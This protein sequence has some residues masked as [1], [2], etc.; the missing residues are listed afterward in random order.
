MGLNENE[1]TVYIVDYGLAKSFIS[2]TTG[3]HIPFSD[4]NK[5]TGTARYASIGTHLGYEQSRRDDLESL[6]Y[7]LVY[8]LKG[9]LPWQRIQVAGKKERRKKICEKKMS[10][11]VESLCKGLPEPFADFLRLSKCL[12][13]EEKPNYQYLRKLFKNYF[14]EAKLN[15]NFVFDWKKPAQKQFKEPQRTVSF[16]SMV[17][18]AH[19]EKKEQLHILNTIQKKL[20]FNIINQKVDER[21]ISEGDKL[22]K[23]PLVETSPCLFTNDSNIAEGD[24]GMYNFDNDDIAESSISFYY[25]SGLYTV[26]KSS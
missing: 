24:S 20:S 4:D 11:T 8:M 7:T 14:L 13:F 25:C 22:L 1:D 16:D 3:K 2:K 9:I 12:S 21:K 19:L 26:R 18:M 15:T 10:T 23:V 5:L 6:G 17:K